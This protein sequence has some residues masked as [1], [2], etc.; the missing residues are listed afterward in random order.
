MIGEIDSGLETIIGASD[1]DTLTITAADD[2][3][4]TH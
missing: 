4:N 2:P 3:P 1:N